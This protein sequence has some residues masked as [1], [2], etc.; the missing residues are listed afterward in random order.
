MKVR[1]TSPFCIYIFVLFFFLLKLDNCEIWEGISDEEAKNVKHLTHDVELQIY[2]QHTLNCVALFCNNT[3]KKCKNVYK[4]FVKASNEVEGYDVTFAYIDTLKLKKTAEN[5]E[6][7]D[8]PKIL[9]F[10]DYDAEKGYTFNKKYTK[11][12]IIEWLKLPPIPSVEVMDRNNVDKYVEM[13]KKKGYAC[14]IAYC[15]KNSDNAHK[16]IHFGETHKIPNLS[17]GLTYVEKDEESKIDILNGPGSTVPNDL[18]KYN[19]TY[20]P[21]SNLWT[22]EQI[23]NFANGYMEQFPV[24]INYNRK[25]NKPEKGE[26]YFY[27]YSHPGGYSDSLYAQ[28]YNIIK[29]NP[30]IKFVFPQREEMLELFGLDKTGNFL[31]LLDYRD[32]SIDVL[33]NLLRPKKYI[34]EV[35]ENIKPE[36][37]SSL[38]D[39][40]Y[41]NKIAQFKKSQKPVKRREKEKYQILCSDNFESFVFDPEKVVLIFYHVEGCKEC[42]PLF[43]FWESVANHFHLEYQNDQVLVATMDAKLN[44]M[45]DQSVNFYPSVAIYP[46]DNKL[47]RRKFLFFPIKLETLIDL[48]DEMLEGATEEDDL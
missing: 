27:L 26:I 23:F 25:G 3:E 30:K 38:I 36:D 7:N 14:I 32:S 5:F 40:F 29:E 4:E 16:F 11:E 6:I 47:K 13:Q 35:G 46:K 44:D 48:V 8:V 22:S 20:K 9:I 37:V 19:D 10:K 43:F 18:I 12:N 21:D 28:L 2:S 15:I 33:Y 17:V 1:C 41:N 39:D 24:N 45:V 31:C 34:R 42:K